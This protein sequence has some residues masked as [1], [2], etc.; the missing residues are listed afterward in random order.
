MAM[1][2]HPSLQTA[3]ES[4]VA[5]GFIVLTLAVFFAGCAAGM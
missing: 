1:P 2:N 5:A 4:S 3:R